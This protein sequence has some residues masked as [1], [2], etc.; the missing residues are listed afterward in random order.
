LGERIDGGKFKLFERPWGFVEGRGSDMFN[1]KGHR[2]KGQ[3]KSGY[4]PGNSRPEKENLMP[5]TKKSPLRQGAKEKGETKK[6]PTTKGWGEQPWK[7]IP[8][9]GATR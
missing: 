3:Q 8:F 6:K 4:G 5:K 7:E 9:D 1:Q 2:K